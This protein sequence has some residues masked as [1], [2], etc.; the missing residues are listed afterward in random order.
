MNRNLIMNREFDNNGYLHIRDLLNSADL[1]PIRRKCTQAIKK[2]GFKGGM[3]KGG[4]NSSSWVSFAQKNPNV[5]SEVYDMMRDDPVL[6]EL[7]KSKKITSIVRKLIK[8]PGLYK[9]IPFRIDVPFETKELAYWHQDDFYVKG[10]PEELTVWIPLFNTKIENGCLMIMPG[11]HKLGPIPHTIKIGK[12]WLP[13]GIYSREIRYVE[14]NC[15]DVLFFSS[16][17]MHSSGFNISN[18]IRYT[19]QLRYTSTELEPSV[20]MLGVENV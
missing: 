1:E 13:E 2:S 4:I 17:L 8:N 19:I 12:K 18:D 7:G 6:T 20:N 11:T 3:S 16:Y 5:V 15:G 10:N 9:K 14:M